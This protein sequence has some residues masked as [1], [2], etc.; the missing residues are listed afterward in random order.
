MN[1]LVKDEIQKEQSNDLSSE[2]NC[3]TEKVNNTEAIL[4]DESVNIVEDE[5]DLMNKIK[6]LIKKDKSKSINKKLLIY[7]LFRLEQKFDFCF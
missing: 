6:L 3:A 7:D 2:D 1:E 5:D 4:I